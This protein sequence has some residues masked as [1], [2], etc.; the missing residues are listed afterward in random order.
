[1]AKAQVNVT[2]NFLDG[3]DKRASIYD[4][5]QVANDISPSY[6]GSQ[7]VAQIRPDMKMNIIRLSGG[8]KDGKQKNTDY[9][10]VRWSDA[11]NDYVYD[12]SRLLNV[13]NKADENGDKI[14][15]MVID[16]VPWCFQR[17]YTFVDLDKN[18]YDG[19]HFR[20]FE[21][22]EQYG[23]ALPPY[24][25]A[26]YG[27]YVEAF[28]Q[29]LVDNYG[30]NRVKNWRFR[31]G[32]EIESPGHWKGTAED[33]IA[34]LDVSMRAIRKVVPDAHIGIHTR[35]PRYS[36]VSVK[37]LNYKGEKFVSFSKE[38][39]D[40][41]SKN[42]L[43]IN[44]WG[45]SYYVQ[46]DKKGE[47]YTDEKWYDDFVLP[48]VSS[49]K[50]NKNTEI[51][52]EEFKA[53][54]SFKG[55]DGTAVTLKSESTHGEVAH[56]ALSNLFYK[57]PEL[58]QIHRWIQTKNTKDDI[59]NKELLTMVGETRYE[60]TVKGKPDISSNVIDA[61]FAKDEANSTYK[62]LLYNY[63]G[64]STSYQSKQPV[65][66]SFVTEFPVGTKFQ[67]RNS[68][69]TQRH[70]KLQSFANEPGFQ[71]DWYVDGINE[72][73]KLGEDK[74]VLKPE[75]YNNRYIP[76]NG[77]LKYAPT[78]WMNITTVPRSDGGNKGSEIVV[79]TDIESFAFRKFEFKP[80]ER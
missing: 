66:L 18:H 70:N 15:Q 52:L 22:V 61:I 30:M 76:Y 5:W 63:N 20:K 69:Y 41:C 48:L 33:F 58:N 56:I 53:T 59:A 67:Y 24:D 11:A 26:E 34:Y 77:Y 35:Q 38:I 14:Y 4:V 2:T 31:I 62:A 12:F 25:M 21:E 13:I 3:A 37:G 78:Q 65:N 50:W 39:L 57:H 60:S 51:N 64:D 55:P 73:Q 17:G 9:D 7:D 28:M 16:N 8:I 40:H 6:E 43:L 75:V 29:T 72:G 19:V 79:K 44:S 1:M 23:N 32:S 46:F 80:V 71:E 74:R 47:F 45:L 10:M 42:N 27:Q 49:P 68:N 36:A 54:A